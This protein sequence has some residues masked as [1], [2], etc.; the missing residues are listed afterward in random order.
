MNDGSRVWFVVALL[1]I[2]HLVLRVALGVGPAAPDFLLIAVLIG[3]RS[4]GPGGGAA[5]GFTLGL[6]ED[7]FS[8]LSFGANTVALT[9]SGI[10]GGVTRDLFVG[11]SGVFQLSFLFV[12]KFLR[13]AA[14]WVL[15]EP[16]VRGDF[17]DQVLI[18]GGAQAAYAAVV[19]TIVLRLTGVWGDDER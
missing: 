6:L 1:V 4:L 12:G 19:G 3:S 15:A 8:L 14:Y 9:L 2:L 7:A 10:L 13:D 17:V 11:D 18:F 5:V 16:T